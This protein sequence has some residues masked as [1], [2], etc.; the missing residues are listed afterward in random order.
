MLIKARMLAPK[1][2]EAAFTAPFP[3]FV[4]VAT[5]YDEGAALIKVPDTDIPAD[6]AGAYVLQL[7]GRAPFSGGKQE[8]TRVESAIHTHL[9]ARYGDMD[10]KTSGA[11]A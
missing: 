2:A 5:L 11:L 7:V 6:I 1:E 8:R 4:M 3:T 10:Y 9:V